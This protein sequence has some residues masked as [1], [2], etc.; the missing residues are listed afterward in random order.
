MKL[1]KAFF[2]LTVFGLMWSCAP[3]QEKNADQ[4]LC[5]TNILADIYSNIL[6]EEIQVNALM[7]PGV[8]PHTYQFKSKDILAIQNT[9]VFI[10]NGLY[11]E[12]NL[13]EMLPQ[14][15]QQKILINLG[16]SLSPDKLIN[17]DQKKDSF[18]PHFW[19]D[20]PL[21]LEAIEANLPQLYQAFPEQKEVIVVRYE[22][23]RNQLIQLHEN[24]L[25][26]MAKI[27]VH[28]RKL[29]TAHDA[30]SYFSRSYGI[31][32]HAIQGVSTSVDYSIKELLDLKDLLIKNQIPAI[33][34]EHSVA[35]Q[36]IEK[37]KNMCIQ[38]DYN[39]VIGGTLYSDALGAVNSPASTFVDYMNHNSKTIIKALK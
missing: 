14:I 38:S 23:Y 25:V 4:V 31:E 29:I 24:M 7:G 19:M 20:I 33:F 26:E 28:R 17:K 11:L 27:P 3:E 37:L 10:V 35:P 5:T 8:D 13:E 16:G 30:F 21:L 9:P 6:P 22:A 32:V 34:L 39:I 12:G 18:D 36:S 2:I 1:N 15:E